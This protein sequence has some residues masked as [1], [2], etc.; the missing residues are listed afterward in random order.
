MILRSYTVWKFCVIFSSFNICCSH[1]EVRN[2]WH[3]RFGHPNYRSL[4]NLCKRKM[5]ICLSI[6]SCRDGLYSRCVLRK[7][8]HESFDK[9]ASW[10]ASTP[11]QL[12]HNDLCGPLPTVSFSGFKYFIT[13]IDYYSRCTWVYFLKLKRAK[14]L[15]SLQKNTHFRCPFDIRPTKFHHYSTKK[16]V[17]LNIIVD[18]VIGMTF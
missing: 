11:L 15:T 5:V 10:H 14:Y 18:W 4:Q 17:S 3:E 1:D 13:F 6:D 16:D 2:I 9:H 8:N 7:N 12:M